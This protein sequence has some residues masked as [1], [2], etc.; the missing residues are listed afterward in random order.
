MLRAEADI[1]GQLADVADATHDEPE[2]KKKKKS[3]SGGTWRAFVRTESKGTHFTAEG[4]RALAVKYRHLTPE[5]KEPY[6]QMGKAATLC[7]KLG[8][9]TFPIYSRQAMST[10][11][12]AGRT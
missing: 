10:R 9:S 4:L 12:H 6:R 5:Q 11:G 2:E 1:S 8:V 3:G 7:G